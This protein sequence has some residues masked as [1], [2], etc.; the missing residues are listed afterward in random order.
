MIFAREGTAT[1][2]CVHVYE[3]D[4]DTDKHVRVDIFHEA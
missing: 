3:H 4:L 2:M 1:G